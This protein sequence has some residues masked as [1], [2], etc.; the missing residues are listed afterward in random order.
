MSDQE[1]I[2]QL[3]E[4]NNI[5]EELAEL[6]VKNFWQGVLFYLKNPEKAKLG[7]YL[8]NLLTFE[9]NKRRVKIFDEMSE[10]KTYKREGSKELR[11]EFYNKLKT[12]LKQHERKNSKKVFD[13]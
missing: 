12:S 6:V 13:E 10:V 11:R 8:P 4:D 1:I 5:S 9:I 7:I 2:K 3:A